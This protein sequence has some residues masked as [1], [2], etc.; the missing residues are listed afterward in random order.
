[1]SYLRLKNETSQEQMADILNIHRPL[2]SNIESYKILPMP[3]AMEKLL[4]YFNCAI[5][6]LYPVE[7]L[8][9][10]CRVYRPKSIEDSHEPARYYNFG[11]RLRV[12]TISPLFTRDN[13]R[14]MGYRDRT[15]W[16]YAKIKEFEA[17]F[18]L[19]QKNTNENII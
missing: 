9:S 15:Q 3:E 5:D 19:F 7:L 16:L 10:I 14:K 8:K 17:E 4:A 12:D 2:I 1:M 13:L 11:A 18:K 6:D